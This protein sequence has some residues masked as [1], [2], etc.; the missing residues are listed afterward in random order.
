MDCCEWANNKSLITYQISLYKLNSYSDIEMGSLAPH[1][2]KNHKLKLN[3]ELVWALGKQLTF[4][5][6]F[7]EGSEME[8]NLGCNKLPD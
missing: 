5:V 3:E 2:A 1:K 7:S 4:T 6:C 8:Q